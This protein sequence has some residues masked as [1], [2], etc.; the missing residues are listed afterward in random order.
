M[1]NNTNIKP[2]KEL[3]RRV[4]ADFNPYNPNYLGD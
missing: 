4:T 2:S 3:K 1:I